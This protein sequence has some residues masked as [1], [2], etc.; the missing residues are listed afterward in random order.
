MTSPRRWLPVD[1]DI[2]PRFPRHLL[3]FDVL[4]AIFAGG[5]AGGLARYALARALPWDGTGFPWGTFTANLAG[6]FALPLL[7]VIVVERLHVRRT[8]QPLLTTGL[9][10]ALTTFSTF[11][12][13]SDRLMSRG[14]A[15]TAAAYVLGSAAAGLTVGLVGL[16]AGEALAE[17][18]GWRG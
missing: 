14:H 18:S 12:V 16:R 13:E 1:P 17:R 8:L 10:G 15:L 5:C 2:F 4:L 9:C 6:A 11:A 3:P 7:L